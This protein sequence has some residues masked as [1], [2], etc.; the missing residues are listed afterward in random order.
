MALQ[1]AWEL[2]AFARALLLGKFAQ[3]SVVIVCRELLSWPDSATVGHV[4]RLFRAAAAVRAAARS[5]VIIF[6]CK[7]ECGHCIELD[8]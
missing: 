2:A 7:L 6:T 8:R 1:G 3:G 4:S 5:T